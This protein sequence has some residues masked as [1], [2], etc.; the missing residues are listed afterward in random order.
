MK[1]ALLYLLVTVA[2]A[3]CNSTDDPEIDN[4]TPPVPEKQAIEIVVDEERLTAYQVVY[5]IYPEDKEAYFYSDVMSKARW[6]SSDLAV[7]K[8]EFLESL[9]NFADM[10]G[11]TYEEVVDQMLFKGDV[12]DFVSNAGYRGNTDFVIFAFY[13]DGSV[14]D[15]CFKE[16]T[17]PAPVTSSED[18]AISF[19]VVDS[20]SMVV[21]LEPTAGVAEYY[22]HFAETQKVDAMLQQ[23]EDE[24]AFISYHAM[25]VGVKYTEKISVEQKGLKPETSYTSIVM[26]IDEQGNRMMTR[27]EQTT[28]AVAHSDLV[29]SQ[30][31]ESLLGE[32]SG[33]QSVFDGYSE[34]SESHFSVTIAQS[35][36]NYDYDYRTNN[37]LVALVDGWNN[38]A[39]YG[40]DGLVAEGVEDP[41]E[42]FGPKW[43]LDIAEGDVVTIDGH[44]RHSV[45]GWMFYGDCFMVSADSNT[46]TVNVD[47]TLNVE[48]SADGNTLTIS[49]PVSNCYPS[50]AYDFTG[51]GWMANFYGMSDIV[52]TRK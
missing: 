11:A 43:V 46:A 18:V 10:T 9:L 45:V 13:W 8:A 4:P 6:E 26:A 52:L 29:D 27:K 39:Y 30:L 17:T 5:S 16:F 36:D 3:A 32:W 15:V 25:N 50:L 1:K 35:V 24:N 49:S 34:P 21:E 7:I 37:Q 38:I 20:Y 14:A 19:D 12:L 48:V 33:T 41:E 31:F 42:K 44:A 22:Y 47:S 28:P 2:L 51:F 40:V 23:L